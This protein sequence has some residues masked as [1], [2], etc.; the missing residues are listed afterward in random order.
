MMRWKLKRISGCRHSIHVS[1]HWITQMVYFPWHKWLFTLCLGIVR[2]HLCFHF[3][4]RRIIYCGFSYS[5]YMCKI[6]FLWISCFSYYIVQTVVKM[7]FCYFIFWMFYLLLRFK[8][9]AGF[10][11]LIIFLYCNIKRAQCEIEVSLTVIVQFN[12]NSTVFLTLSWPAGHMC[13]TY[14][15]FFQV[16]WDNSIPLFLHAAI[17]LE[18]SLFR[19]TSQNA[20]SHETAVYKWYCVQ[21]CMQHCTQYQ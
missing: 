5:G 13:P 9:H 2:F 8:S 14:K 20:F 21:C 15:E 19:W 1:S 18:V 4:R 16:H 10:S 3:C 17:Y 12:C 6:W 7:V 11:L